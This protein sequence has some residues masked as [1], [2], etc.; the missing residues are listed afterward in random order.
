MQMSIMYLIRDIMVLYE[1]ESDAEK[2]HE[3]HIR[4]P[5]HDEVD[6]EFPLIFMG[7]PL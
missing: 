2:E 4:C 1:Q 5:V 3:E 7:D 6:L